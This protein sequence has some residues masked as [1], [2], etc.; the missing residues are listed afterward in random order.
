MTIRTTFPT[1]PYLPSL[2]ALM[3]AVTAC[4][5]GDGDAKTIENSPFEAGSQSIQ[6]N[7]SQVALPIDPI[8]LSTAYT[9]VPAEKSNLG[10]C[11]FA[12][13]DAVDQ[14]L[15]RQTE[16]TVFETTLIEPNECVWSNAYTWSVSVARVPIANKISPETDRYNLDIE[17]N[18]QTL[19]SPGQDAVMLSDQI[20][21]GPYAVYFESEGK[22]LQIRLLGV[23]TS[24]EKL[25]AFAETVAGNSDAI[26][27]LPEQS[28][29]SNEP[30][31][32]PCEVLNGAHIAS[33][34]A[35]SE[36]FSAGALQETSSCEYAGFDA[37][38]NRLTLSISFSGDALEPRRL[39]A[40]ETPERLD[41][42]ATPVFRVASGSRST[43]YGIDHPNG[44]IMI[45]VNGPVQDED[46]RLSKL[47]S[48]LTSRLLF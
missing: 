44:H 25:A 39:N 48:N 21:Q 9:F 22:Q 11:G 47:I 45:N 32:E 37:N 7:L 35:S 41:E 8:D 34:F 17:P 5:G 12:S 3:L 18:V 27:V 24:S 14:L 33:V 46:E 42:F 28:S 10:E 30:T 19:S 29:I 31:L 15:K 1:L 40:Y 26:M 6:Q 16:N 2:A 38:G 13:L 23:A 20:L 43:V 36:A 4:S